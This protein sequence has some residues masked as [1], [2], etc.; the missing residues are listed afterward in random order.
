MSTSARAVSTTQDIFSWSSGLSQSAHF[1][2]RKPPGKNF[3]HKMN[4]SYFFF[5]YTALFSCFISF[6]DAFLRHEE[7]YEKVVLPDGFLNE[8][9]ESRDKAWKPRQGGSGSLPTVTNRPPEQQ[10]AGDRD[11]G[12]DERAQQSIAEAA[13][14]DYSRLDVV[15]GHHR[16]SDQV[17]RSRASSKRAHEEH[18]GT[19][20]TSESERDSTSRQVTALTKNHR[21]AA[22]PS[23][24]RTAN[25][26]VSEDKT[27][28]PVGT[29]P[30]ALPPP[31]A[32]L[33]KEERR[34]GVRRTGTSGLVQLVHEN[35]VHQNYAEG[36]GREQQYN[37]NFAQI[38]SGHG[39]KAA[40][41]SGSTS[42][43]KIIDWWTQ[44][45]TMNNR[46]TDSNYGFT[47]T[48]NDPFYYGYDGSATNGDYTN[49]D[50]NYYDS[51]TPLA[52]GS[53]SSYPDATKNSYTADYYYN[54]DNI[55]TPV[56]PV[57]YGLVGGVWLWWH[58][59]WSVALGLR[60]PPLSSYEWRAAA[61]RQA[62]R[63]AEKQGPCYISVAERQ[64]C[65]VPAVDLGMSNTVE[66]CMKKAHRCV[67]TGCY[68]R[69]D[70]TPGAGGLNY[71][72]GTNNY[73]L[74]QTAIS[75]GTTTDGTTSAASSST[76]VP[77]TISF[78]RP[79]FPGSAFR[80]LLKKANTG[81][82]GR[83]VPDD[84]FDT[85]LLTS[86]R[87]ALP[88]TQVCLTK[89]EHGQYCRA[90]MI[91]TG[92]ARTPAECALHIRKQGSKFVYG[93]FGPDAGGCYELF[94]DGG[95][96]V[97]TSLSTRTT[98][99]GGGGVTSTNSY[100]ASLFDEP[101]EFADSSCTLGLALDVHYDMYRVSDCCEFESNVISFAWNTFCWL[102][103]V[104]LF[105]IPLWLFLFCCFLFC[106]DPQYSINAYFNEPPDGYFLRNSDSKAA[107][108]KELQAEANLYA[109]GRALPRAVVQAGAASGQLDG[110]G[111]VA[112]SVG[113]QLGPQPILPA[114]GAARIP[115]QDQ[116]AAAASQAGQKVQTNATNYFTA[117]AVENYGYMESTNAP[118]AGL[119]PYAAPPDSSFV[120]TGTSGTAAA[121]SAG[122]VKT[123]LQQSRAVV[124]EVPQKQS[125]SS[126]ASGTTTVGTRS[127]PAIQQMP[128]L[129]EDQTALVSGRTDQNG[130]LAGTAAVAATGNN[131]IKPS[132]A[133]ATTSSADPTV[134]TRKTRRARGVEEQVLT[135]PP[136]ARLGENDENY[137]TNDQQQPN[138]NVFFS[139][140]DGQAYF[141]SDQVRSSEQQISGAEDDGSASPRL[142]GTPT[143]DTLVQD[144]R[145]KVT[146]S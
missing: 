137:G 138:G 129:Q 117:S 81:C 104:L 127:V 75:G 14:G 55:N 131:Y 23:A 59:F 134:V 139:T 76:S 84:R 22:S 83:L 115:P 60:A 86:C 16:E 72:A 97:L 100:S 8:Q 91:Y 122:T 53:P 39:N 31:S 74:Q 121:S 6:A 51:T 141:S 80:C 96:G 116:A 5:L 87:R 90:P 109:P 110:G 95:E 15:S 28:T 79:E 27:R 132:G 42:D 71:I 17:Q 135:G 64:S 19:T 92:K 113:V 88:K 29:T 119:V 52:S 10:P 70:T 123:A 44:Q 61:E 69:M 2:S 11:F 102:V 38:S 34:G 85:F 108:A 26:M 111:G 48:S 101:D 18:K 93:D 25:Y 107:V 133:G 118:G 20:R 32:L 65:P 54:N 143:E 9:R 35:K 77:D 13:Q 89:L 36:G 46:N 146:P 140:D 24:Q 56:F 120:A 30:R 94:D 40:T 49:S 73:A 66:S 99:F 125:A 103:F 106:C 1:H 41:T 130:G 37:K 68:G 62:R 67:Q 136:S 58:H 47:S 105:G 57:F 7:S 63:T 114:P 50:N 82:Y 33:Q 142:A 12:Y 112:G 145:G 43:K 4:M 144:T 98:L 128:V 3:Q 45:T 78:G 126:T 21:R 124:E